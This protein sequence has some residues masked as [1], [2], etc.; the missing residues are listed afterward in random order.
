MQR[1]SNP[2]R[3]QC[4]TNGKQAVSIVRSGITI[5]QNGGVRMGQDAVPGVVRLDFPTPFLS[6]LS[7]AQNKNQYTLSFLRDE[8]HDNCPS[9]ARAEY[10][11]QA[12]YNMKK[13]N[14]IYTGI[15]LFIFIG[16]LSGCSREPSAA[17]M[18]ALARAETEVLRKN[19][20]NQ[21]IPDEKLPILHRFKKIA[22]IAATNEP[23]YKCDAEAD[24]EM[25]HLGLAR[26][27][28][29]IQVRYVKTSEGWKTLDAHH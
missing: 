6:V 22:C 12:N 16:G 14:I 2:A 13:F 11:H 19:A 23:G 28:T 25:P 1:A 8:L 29:V 27:A 10:H 5:C 20:Q 9:L 24:M 15:A 17:D 26:R 7:S 3:T 4:H 21:G 18:E